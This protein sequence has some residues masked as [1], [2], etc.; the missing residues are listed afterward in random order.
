MPEA[1]VLAFEV[2][3]GVHTVPH[4]VALRLLGMGID[5]DSSKLELGGGA[6]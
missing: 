1:L 3:A 2:P 4:T 6:G 5:I